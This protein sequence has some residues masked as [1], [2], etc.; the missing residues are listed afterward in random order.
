MCPTNGRILILL[1]TPRGE[2]PR[3]DESPTEY[4]GPFNAQTPAPFDP[5]AMWEAL[6]ARDPRPAPFYPG[7]PD[8]PFADL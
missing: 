3:I 4:V 2:D 5:T 6:E 8:D 1:V 7:S